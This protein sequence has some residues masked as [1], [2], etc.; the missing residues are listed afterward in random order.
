MEKKTVDTAYYVLGIVFFALVV[1]LG[2]SFLV[3]LGYTLL[4]KH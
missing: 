2:V 1:F 4:N 3:N